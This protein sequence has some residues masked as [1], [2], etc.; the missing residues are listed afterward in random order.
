MRP[1]LFLLYISTI[2]YKHDIKL[3]QN[4]IEITVE[5]VRISNFLGKYN[6]NEN[7][8]FRIL[9]RNNY[10]LLS[11][12][13]IPLVHFG[14]SIMYNDFIKILEEEPKPILNTLIM[15]IITLLG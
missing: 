8:T 10:A 13:G 7:I 9:N 1:W 5:K 15:L 3:S 12:A 6:F 14:S 4:E 2:S 11:M